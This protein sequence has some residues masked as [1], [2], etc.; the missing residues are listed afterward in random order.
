M[1]DNNFFNWLGN[2]LGSLIR[3]IVGVL[4]K[5]LGS[6]GTAIREFS[7]SLAHAIGMNPSTFNFAL[8]ILG[9]LLL[10]A[11]ISAFARRSILGGIIWL[12]LAVLVLGGLTG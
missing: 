9:L 3:V 6:F 5:V 12:I 11:A 2:A 10:F 7:T 4:Q 1:N 8:L